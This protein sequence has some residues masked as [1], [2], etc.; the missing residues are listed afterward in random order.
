MRHSKAYYAAKREI[1]LRISLAIFQIL[2][3]V[4]IQKRFQ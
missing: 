1:Q 3:P 2:T 4:I